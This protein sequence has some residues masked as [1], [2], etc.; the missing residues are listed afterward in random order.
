MIN[1]ERFYN[2]RIKI[3]RPFSDLSQDEKD[4]LADSLSYALFN[5]HIA[6]NNLK[7]E[8]KKAIGL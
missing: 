4:F 2:E 6:W 5:F 7:S 1:L 8:I 3:T